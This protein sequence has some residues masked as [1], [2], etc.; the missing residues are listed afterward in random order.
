EG[1]GG[2]GT[3]ASERP[4]DPGEDLAVCRHW[5]AA[6]A[7]PP[8]GFAALASCLRG[9]RP[10]LAW[11]QT[12]TYRRNPPSPGFLDAYGHATIAGPPEEPSPLLV[13]PTV[14]S[15]V[16]L[17]GP[18]TSYPPHRHPAEEV[19]LPLG[20]A[21]WRRGWEPWRGEPGG[22]LVHHRP[23][24]AHAIRTG[25]RPLLAVYAWCGDVTTPSRLTA[26]LGSQVG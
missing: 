23:S 8:L 24:V 17:L 10:A 13:A 7:D 2:A 18:H 14:R 6:L 11:T 25:D 20:P 22:A 9:L 16:L 15:G 4:G 12:G 5:D 19:Y 21:Q 3:R 26:P 1:D